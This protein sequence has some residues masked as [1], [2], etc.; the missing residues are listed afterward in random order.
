MDAEVIGAWVAAADDDRRAVEN[1]LHGPKPTIRAA[2]YHSQQAAEKLIKAVLVSTE[3]HPPRTHDLG[4]LLDLLPAGNPLL[5]V[6][7]PLTFL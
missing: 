3:Q 2:A 5:P 1:N 4:A 6:L 7:T